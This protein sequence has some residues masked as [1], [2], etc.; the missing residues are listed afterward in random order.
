M[1][2]MALLLT[3]TVIFR[4]SHRSCSVKKES[5]CVG[6]SFINKV[7]A[8]SLKKRLQHRCSPENFVKFLRT[9]YLQNTSGRLLIK[10]WIL[11]SVK[12]D[13]FAFD[14][15]MNNLTSSDCLN[16]PLLFLRGGGKILKIGF[17]RGVENFEGEIDKKV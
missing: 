5:T 4:S 11:Y 1:N 9:P 2:W 6:V 16:P 14:T 3:R 10:H 7:A 12:I 13:L 8:T 15:K 17:N